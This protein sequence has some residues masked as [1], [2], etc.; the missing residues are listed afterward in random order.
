LGLSGGGL[1]TAIRRSEG[2]L[3]EFNSRRP[4]MAEARMPGYCFACPAALR[5]I[6]REVLANGFSSDIVCV[7]TETIAFMRSR[8]FRKSSQVMM[9]WLT[10]PFKIAA[11]S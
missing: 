5:G 9:I 11:I 1:Q 3:A 2:G 8:G 10:L 7:Q 6:E 4:S